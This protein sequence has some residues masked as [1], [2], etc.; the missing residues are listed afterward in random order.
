MNHH[1]SFFLKDSNSYLEYKAQILLFYFS[2]FQFEHI[3]MYLRNRKCMRKCSTTGRLLK[4]AVSSQTIGRTIFSMYQ[5]HRMDFTHYVTFRSLLVPFLV[6]PIV[7]LL[8]AARL[9]ALRHNQIWRPPP[10]SWQPHV[11]C[12]LLPL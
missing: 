3:S 10:E 11:D 6:S 7:S 9:P 5:A 12:L 8:L 4:R 2:F 1:Q